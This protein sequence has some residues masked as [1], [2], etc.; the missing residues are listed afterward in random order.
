MLRALPPV[1]CDVQ[2]QQL[3]WK[4]KNLW[5]FPALPQ[6]NC[7]ALSSLSPSPLP[8]GLSL[9]HSGAGGG[10]TG[11][12]VPLSWHRTNPMCRHR[13]PVFPAGAGR[14]QAGAVVPQPSGLGRGSGETRRRPRSRHC[15]AMQPNPSEPAEEPRGR[16]VSAVAVRG[17]R[18]REELVPLTRAGAIILG[19]PS[20]F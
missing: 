13:F 17:W 11:I 6:N 7:S 20:L 3:P 19:M 16:S 14:A 4:G 18:R 8:K 15:R 9:R 10:C 5:I 12:V 1:L 2:C